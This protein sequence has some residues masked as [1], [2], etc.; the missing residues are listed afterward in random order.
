MAIADAKGYPISV[1]ATSATPHEVK[2]VLSTLEARVTLEQPCRLIGDKAYD[3]D[4]LDQQCKEI[5]V[6]LIAPHK[7]NR[8]KE[9]TQDGRS[10]R[11]YQRRWKVERLFAWLHNYRRLI[12][13]FDYKIENF[14]AFLEL[15]AFMIL[16]KKYL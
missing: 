11:R 4:L 16:M 1:L 8:R 6:E 5:G 13:R 15:G 12:N 2:L 10:L 7:A 14:Q 9:V 3:S